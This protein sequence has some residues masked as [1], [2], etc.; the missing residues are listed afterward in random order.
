MKLLFST[1]NNHKL[2]ELKNVLK[3]HHVD[4][5]LLSL[6]DL[7]ISINP[8]ETG[9]TLIENAKIKCE[10]AYKLSK[11]PCIADDTGL[12]VNSLEGEPGVYSARY[13]GFNSSDSENREKLLDNLNGITDRKAFFKTIIYFTDGLNNYDFEGIC[14]GKIG[15]SEKGNNGFGYDSIFVPEG[16]DKTFAE[17]S[18]EVKNRIS[19]RAIATNKFSTFLKKNLS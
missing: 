14:N 17:L 9:K 11:I 4:I 5:T 15:Y 7:N 2:I 3:S 16:Y 12:F 13:A 10:A 6:N 19:H 18:S 1:N 8:K